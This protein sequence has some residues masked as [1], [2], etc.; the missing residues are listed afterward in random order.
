MNIRIDDGARLCTEESLQHNA[1]K[2]AGTLFCITAALLVVVAGS[3]PLLAQSS[4]HFAVI[5]DYGFAGNP[6]AEVAKLVK[7]WKPDFIITTG[8]NN[9]DFGGDSSIDRNI[10]QYYHEFISPYPGS[11]GHGD[12]VN[13]FFPSLGN[14]DWRAAGA[15]PYLKYFT[16]PGN[17]RYYDIVRGPVHLFAI[18]SD[19]HEADGITESSVQA[20]WLKQG[21]AKSTAR[22]KIV[23]FHHAP[24]S[25][26]AH[27]N[28]PT[29]QWPFKSWGASVVITGHDHTYERAI[30][31][32]FPYFVNGVGGRS[33]YDM[34]KPIKGSVVRFNADYGA[35]DIN[36]DLSKMEIR[37]VTR[38]DSVVDTY[39][40]E[41]PK[42]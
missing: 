10:G 2:T 31:D 5:G 7:T 33:L 17:E 21:L 4:V 30:V 36:A 42:R 15:A 27:G 12:T 28:N 23:Y 32:G 41:A 26:G 9:Y 6:E 3:Q 14:H 16:L 11:F 24:Y 18:D 20:M 35:M 19:E 25:S 40:I 37:F 1:V 34:G 39:T 29:L 22:W 13:R 38:K 8:D